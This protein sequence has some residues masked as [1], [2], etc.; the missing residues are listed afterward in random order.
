MNLVEIEKA[1]KKAGMA[2]R[3]H[4]DGGLEMVAPGA[5]LYAD[6]SGEVRVVQGHQADG[7]R[8]LQDLLAAATGKPRPRRSELASVRRLAIKAL[9]EARRRA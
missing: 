8:A 1:A 3:L 7:E 4:P 9:L 2:T 6:H 5:N